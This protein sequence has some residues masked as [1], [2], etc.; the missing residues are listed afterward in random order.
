MDDYE[1][2]LVDGVS[3]LVIE[4]VSNEKGND[5]F[6][7]MELFNPSDKLIEAYYDKKYKDK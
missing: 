5:R 2:V 7:A 1:V 4:T 3:Y 6:K